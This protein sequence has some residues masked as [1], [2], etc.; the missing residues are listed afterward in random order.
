MTTLIVASLVLALGQGQCKAQA[1]GL[2]S[3][4]MMQ[5]TKP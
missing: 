2:P 3:G 1:L 4:N 5:M